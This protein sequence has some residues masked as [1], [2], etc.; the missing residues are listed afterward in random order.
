MILEPDQTGLVCGYSWSS[1]A[2][3]LLLLFAAQE[4]FAST[5]EAGTDST[6][7]NNTCKYLF[8]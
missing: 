6:K 7:K 1:K 5:E 4:F 8:M 2:K 3:V